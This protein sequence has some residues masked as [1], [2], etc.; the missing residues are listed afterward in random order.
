MEKLSDECPK[1]KIKRLQEELESQERRNVDMA[2][3]VLKEV[4]ETF[5][6]AISYMAEQCQMMEKVMS[7]LQSTQLELR[8]TR[9]LVLSVSAAAIVV[10][11]INN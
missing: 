10:S 8:L 1:A 7:K 3:S 9:F 11:F 6:S 2:H 4:S 5:Q